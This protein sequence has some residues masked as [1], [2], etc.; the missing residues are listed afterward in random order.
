MNL[1]GM[2]VSF[3]ISL[4]IAFILIALDVELVIT[5]IVSII[6]FLL[7]YFIN[8]NMPFGIYSIFR[9]AAKMNRQ[10]GAKY[11]KTIGSDYLRELPS[12]YTPALVSFI[13]DESI[14]YNKDVL[15]ALLKLIN[16]GYLKIENDRLVITD[17][18]YSKLYAHE[19]YLCN[20][21]KNGTQVKFLEFK[22]DLIYDAKRLELVS[23]ADNGNLVLKGIMNIFFGGFRYF[24]ILMIIVVLIT[25]IKNESAVMVIMIVAIIFMFLTFINVF[26]RFGK[27]ISY[28]IAASTKKVK[29]SEKGKI[30]QEKIY[31]FKNFLKDFTDLD[32]KDTIDIHLWD[33]YLIYALVLDVN[34]NIYND[35]KLKR[36]VNNVQKII[37]SDFK[38]DILS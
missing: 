22:D 34:K 7:I 9:N 38:N 24:P 19:R 30:D 37:V 3:F 2:L 5:I 13:Q 20:A 21:I 31:M 26:V 15:G 35:E 8:R 29:L 10:S 14:E 4:F 28:F 1:I 18:D 16:D 17:K 27:G 32:K 23:K 6:T 12:Y 36:I 25:L 11:N 33:E